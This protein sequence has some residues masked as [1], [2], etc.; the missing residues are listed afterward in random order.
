MAE[1]PKDFLSSGYIVGSTLAISPQLEGYLGGM[2]S[3]E[4]LTIANCRELK[5]LP[6]NVT[7]LIGWRSGCQM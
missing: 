7:V 2:T 6:A 3:L 4:N 5:T 1:C